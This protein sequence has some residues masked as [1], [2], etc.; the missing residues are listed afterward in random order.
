MT[1]VFGVLCQLCT[2]ET[3]K[4]IFMLHVRDRG[5]HRGRKRDAPR[6]RVDSDPLLRSRRKLHGLT[7]QRELV[8]LPS[9]FMVKDE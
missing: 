2:N 3:P 8:V 4:A 9:R 5:R 6:K 1:I 7:F